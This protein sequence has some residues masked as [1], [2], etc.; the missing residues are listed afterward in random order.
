MGINPS[1]KVF[2]CEP[3]LAL[4]AIHSVQENRI[5]QPS[6]TDT[7]AEGLRT[8]L[9]DLTLSIHHKQL[10]GFF[11][12]EEEE[13]VHEMQMAFERLKIVIEPSSAVALAPLLRGEP[14]LQ[15]K[16][17]GVIMTGGNVDLS[18]FFQKS[19]FAKE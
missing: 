18:A 17:V 3:A 19:I 7:M 4:D 15:G 14:T 1:I 9:G 6:R 11:V 10:E 12:V 16:R 5:I 8:S 13:I 2:A